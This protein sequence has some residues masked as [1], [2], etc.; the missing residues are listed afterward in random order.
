MHGRAWPQTQ[1]RCPGS[2]ALSPPSGGGRRSWPRTTRRAARHTLWPGAS[3]V[4]LGPLPKNRNPLEGGDGVTGF[5]PFCTLWTRRSPPTLLPPNVGR[6]RGSKE[7]TRLTFF[8]FRDSCTTRWEIKFILRLICARW[9]SRFDVQIGDKLGRW[10][11]NGPEMPTIWVWRPTPG[12][13]RKRRGAL[14]ALVTLLP[15]LRPL[16][17]ALVEIQF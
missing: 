13:F 17:Q 1:I 10:K 4:P 3:A 5:I 14:M 12:P 9:W 11:E 6:G 8:A 15:Q 2:S 16:D 7:S